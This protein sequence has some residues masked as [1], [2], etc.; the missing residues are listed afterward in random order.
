MSQLQ[1]IKDYSL[2]PIESIVPF[3]A[4]FHES[5]CV[6]G[7]YSNFRVGAALLTACGHIITGANVENVHNAKAGPLVTRRWRTPANGHRQAAFPTG[8][9]AERTALGTAIASAKASKFKAIGVATDKTDQDDGTLKGFCSPCGNCRQALREFCDVRDDPVLDIGFNT[10]MVFFGAA[11]KPADMEYLLSSE[12][13]SI[14]SIAA[15]N[16]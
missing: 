7:P 4:L 5:H 13:L 6:L 1:R 3:H 15:A 10:S 2:H 12:R 8:T 11:L 16:M 14:C 9:C